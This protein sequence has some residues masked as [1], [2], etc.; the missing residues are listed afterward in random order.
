MSWL[1]VGF[2]CV[3]ANEPPVATTD[4]APVSARRPVG[5]FALKRPPPRPPA[6]VAPH[7][8]TTGDYTALL[9]FF[10]CAPHWSGEKHCGRGHVYVFSFSNLSFGL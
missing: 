1:C 4:D 10:V 5:E 6:T 2:F 8:K 9:V 7:E 3:S